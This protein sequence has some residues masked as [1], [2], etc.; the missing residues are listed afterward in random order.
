MEENNH[1]FWFEVGS[2]GLLFRDTPSVAQACLLSNYRVLSQFIKTAPGP[3][4]PAIIETQEEDPFMDAGF[5]F[6]TWNQ[7]GGAPP[8]GQ[9][10]DEIGRAHV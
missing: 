1:G 9:G 6:D 7:G 3:T 2:D 4:L 10:I 5:S 8:G